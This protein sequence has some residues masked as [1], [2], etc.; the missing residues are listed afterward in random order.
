MTSSAEARTITEKFFYTNNQAPDMDQLRHE[1]WRLELLR[2]HGGVYST[3]FLK[4]AKK[5]LKAMMDAHEGRKPTGA[6]APQN[7]AREAFASGWKVELPTI[8]Q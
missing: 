3:G 6:C 2:R 5:Q 1:I 7:K 4:A 8:R